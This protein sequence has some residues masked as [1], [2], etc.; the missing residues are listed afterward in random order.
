MKCHVHPPARGKA[1]VMRVAGSAASKRA[2][3]CGAGEG[4]SMTRRQELLLA[5]AT[6]QAACTPPAFSVMP[7]V[8]AGPQGF[9]YVS[10]PLVH[11]AAQALSHVY[12]PWSRC[13]TTIWHHEKHPHGMSRFDSNHAACGCARPLA[14]QFQQPWQQN[15][16]IRSPIPHSQPTCLLMRLN[17]L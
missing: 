3:A 4:H 11:A 13:H 6:F 9:K 12:R 1:S 10:T 7:D 17:S 5:L 16:L 8:D 14:K 2:I 15:S